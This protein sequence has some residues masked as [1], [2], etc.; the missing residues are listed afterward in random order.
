MSKRDTGNVHFCNALTAKL[1]LRINYIIYGPTVAY[2]NTVHSQISR[3]SFL[4]RKT[5]K[6]LRSESDLTAKIKRETT[7]NADK[8]SGSED[9]HDETSFRKSE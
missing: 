4:L 8:M 6:W 5:A 7:A 9:E 1:Q 3:L 2:I